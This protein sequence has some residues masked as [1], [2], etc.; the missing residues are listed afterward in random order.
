MSRAADAEQAR[1]GRSHFAKGLIVLRSCEHRLS[2][3][4]SRPRRKAAFSL[5]AVRMAAFRVF[6]AVFVGGPLV[7][8]SPLVLSI[9]GSGVMMLMP[10]AS[11]RLGHPG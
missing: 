7:V 10:A 11:S 5:I 2:I 9:G 4:R 3:T 1:S 6:L 8:G